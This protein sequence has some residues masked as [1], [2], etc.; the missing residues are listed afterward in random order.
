MNMR[1]P[2][3]KP[4]A[5]SASGWHVFRPKHSG[6]PACLLCGRGKEDA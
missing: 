4:C 1:S 6:A 2:E 3:L 5:K